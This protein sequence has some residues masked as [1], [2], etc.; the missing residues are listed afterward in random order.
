MPIVTACFGFQSI[1]FGF[2]YSPAGVNR[3]ADL[4][5]NH[6]KRVLAAV[7]AFTVL[8]IAIGHDVEH[9]LKAAGFTDPSSESEQAGR[10]LSG[11]L[12]YDANPAVELVVRA[13]D[14]GPLD[15][16]SP[17]VRHE[18]ARL[19]SEVE[20]V[21]YVGHVINPLREPSAKALIA[22]DGRSLVIAVNLSTTD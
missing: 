10:V 11:A 8:A 6:P 5:W 21:E 18:V 17:A 19:S 14:G 9:H 16:Q 12:G 22:K 20:K 4:T 2:W 7:A 1:Y 3:I 13:P 15:T